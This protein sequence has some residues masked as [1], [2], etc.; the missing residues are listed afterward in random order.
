MEEYGFFLTYN[1]QSEIIRLP[2]NPESLDLKSGVNGN[3]YSIVDF[4]EINTIQFTKLREI[5]FNSFFPAQRYPF[6]VGELREPL[7]YINMIKEWME[8]R[9]P[10]RF[11]FSGITS[12][13]AAADDNTES[14]L[15]NS[16]LTGTGTFAINMAA[17]IESFDWSITAGSQDVDYTI[18]LKE[19]VFYEPR[20][21]SIST[22]STEAKKTVT[23]KRASD[24]NTPKSYTLKSD[25]SLWSVAKKTLGDGSRYKEIQKMNNIADSELKKLPVGKVLK[26]PSN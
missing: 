18:S 13:T 21:V 19:Y 26:L 5:S 7:Y 2:V 24:K 8:S 4:G 16:G 25:D 1:N 6:V 10:I 20:K 23:Q 3:S 15:L 22:S 11:V 9:N 17:S 12:T 14:E